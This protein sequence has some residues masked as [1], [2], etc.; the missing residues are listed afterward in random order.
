MLYLMD[1]EDQG[2]VVEKTFA[3]LGMKESDVEDLLRK[4]IELVCDDDENM[5]VIGEQVVNEEKARSDLTALDGDGNIV[6]IEIKRDPA[7]IKMRAEAF[8][9]QAIRY[10]A[11]CASIT[12]IDELVQY[13][14]GRY[15]EQHKGEFTDTDKLTSTE[16]A[17]RKLNQ[18]IDD[19]D[20]QTFNAQQCIILVASDFDDQ[21]ISAV[22]WLDANNVD[23]SCYRLTP[24]QVG[25]NTL[26]HSTKILP[27]G[28]YQDLYVGVSH[29]TSQTSKSRRVSGR[30][31][32]SKPRIK[33]LIEA[34]VVD[35]GATLYA[36][37]HENQRVTLLQDGKVKLASGN[38]ISLNAWLQ[39]V[40]GWSSVDVYE[41]AIDE[42]THKTL[43]ELRNAWLIAQA[44]ADAQEESDAQTEENTSTAE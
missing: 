26:I 32:K 14:Y 44:K 30:T 39:G 11:T 34:G 19:S 18:F 37:N 22:A 29:T 27:L 42:K 13:V 5:L 7:D 2:N 1:D 6:L 41:W 25:D 4:H 23:I 16:V 21:T 20:I 8:E 35:V 24:Y 3:E 33:Q 40:Y 15:V 28:S 12:T 36:K 38:V 31:R 10:A 17:T 9:F 43:D